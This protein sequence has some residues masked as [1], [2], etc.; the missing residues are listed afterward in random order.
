MNPLLPPF[1]GRIVC[2]FPDQPRAWFSLAIS[3]E[4]PSQADKSRHRRFIFFAFFVIFSLREQGEG[5]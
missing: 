4:S 3:Q 1:G 2:S 5:L